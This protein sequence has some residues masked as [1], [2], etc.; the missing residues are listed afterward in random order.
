MGQVDHHFATPVVE[1]GVVELVVLAFA[2]DDE[3]HRLCRPGRALQD[4]RHEGGRN[5]RAVLGRARDQRAVDP[6]DQR[7]AAR[8]DDVVE[9]DLRVRPGVDDGPRRQRC[10]ETQVVR[11]VA[12]TPAR[13]RHG[14]DLE[15][16]HVEAHGTRAAFGRRAGLLQS[17]GIA[18]PAGLRFVAFIAGTFAFAGH[19]L[20]Q[21]HR[22]VSEHAQA[23]VAAR[24]RRDAVALGPGERDAQGA[25]LGDH[26]IGLRDFDDTCGDDL[27]ERQAGRQGRGR[28]RG[29]VRRGR[30]CR[31]SRAGGRR[32]SGDRGE[33][34][35]R[36]QGIDL[37]PAVER[38][39]QDVG[40]LDDHGRWPL[41]SVAPLIRGSE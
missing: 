39:E 10:V 25:D 41:E 16:G 37:Q 18:A 13:Q 36:E 17:K 6:V 9:I 35:D 28:S 34:I 29:P 5:A 2:T 12:F 23:D 31:G 19:A 20:E 24:L 22:L 32:R 3:F 4:Q 11:R 15:D 1:R 40:F 27:A 38:C 26:V 21:Q 33:G 30:R 7:R 14:L 8:D